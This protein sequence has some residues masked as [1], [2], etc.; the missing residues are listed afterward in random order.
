MLIEVPRPMPLVTWE[1]GPPE[2]LEVIQAHLILTRR[3]TGLL[4]REVYS[5]LVVAGSNVEL[6][7]VDAQLIDAVQR[8]LGSRVTCCSMT[9]PVHYRPAE[10][11]GYLHG[12]RERQVHLLCWAEFNELVRPGNVP[13]S[14]QS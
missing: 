11:R 7:A 8:F 6:A 2:D 14:W 13:F 1:P 3:P 10:R 4:R 12:I 5:S 9:V